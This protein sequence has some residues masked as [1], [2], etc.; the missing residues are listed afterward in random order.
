MAVRTGG[1]GEVEEDEPVPRDKNG[2]VTDDEQKAAQ[3]S[4][5]LVTRP[6]TTRY[7]FTQVKPSL[8]PGTV[9]EPHQRNAGQPIPAPGA[10]HRKAW[11]GPA[12][13][14]RVHP[15][16]TVSNPSPRT[17]NCRSLSW[18][19]GWPLSHSFRWR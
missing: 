15:P 2:N 4:R 16:I 1:R 3:R 13:G 10:D 8:D 7:A 12:G 6:A 19:S 14:G 11:P 5:L 18:N 9:P 17:L